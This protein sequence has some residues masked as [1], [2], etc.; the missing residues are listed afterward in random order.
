MENWWIYLIF[1]VFS[2]L[3]T[4]IFSIVAGRYGK[5]SEKGI[6]SASGDEKSAAEIWKECGNHREPEN[7]EMDLPAED[8]FN[9]EITEDES[10]DEMLEGISEEEAMEILRAL[11]QEQEK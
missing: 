4:M 10:L 7:A 8:F 5:V 9:G 1:I 11:E 6:F 3:G 2:L